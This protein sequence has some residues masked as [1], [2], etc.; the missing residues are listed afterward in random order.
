MNL[1][2]DAGDGDIYATARDCL[3]SA[4]PRPEIQSFHTIGPRF[5][6]SQEENKSKERQNQDE[7]SPRR[8]L[9]SS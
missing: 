1:S 3:Q 5:G 4:G 7:F 6:G 2:S 8:L 9:T